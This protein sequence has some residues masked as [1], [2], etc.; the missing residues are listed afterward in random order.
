MCGVEKKRRLTAEQV[1]FLETSFSMDLKLEPE[2]KAHLAKQLGIQPRQVAIWFQNRR[3]RWKNQQIEQDY[4]SLKASYEA[5]VEEKERLLKEHDLALEAN[6]RLQ[7]E[8]ARLTRSLQSYDRNGMSEPKE[9][10]LSSGKSEVMST[11]KSVN[12]Q[13]ETQDSGQSYQ[14]APE[15]AIFTSTNPCIDQLSSAGT[16]GLESVV[17][18]FPPPENNYGGVPI[19]VQQLIAKGYCTEFT[20]N[21]FDDCEKHFSGFAWNHL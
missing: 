13:S 8:I 14:T 16:S 20:Y 12:D 11:S 4:E 15:A 18:T 10:Q 17:P 5:V 3:A 1:N 19:L 2:R 9:E 7:A 6:K 21:V